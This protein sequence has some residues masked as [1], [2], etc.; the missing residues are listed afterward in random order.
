MAYQNM[1]RVA[2]SLFRKEPDVLI[3]LGLDKPVPRKVAAFSQVAFTL[4]NTT[5]Y[6]QPMRTK[7]AEHGY[8]DGKL[9]SERSKLSAFDFAKANQEACKGAAQRA[10]QVQHE[11]LRAM[12][13]WYSTYVN[14][15]RVALRP[16]P[17]LL[18]KL[19]IMYRSVKTPAQRQAPLK[20]A[21]TRRRKKEVTLAKA[22]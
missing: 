1:A 5:K 2:R 13:D 17:E 22:A 18:E 3:L 15:A 21:E 12:R 11:A 14:V 20:A 8:T 10:K 16:K 19:G 7:L 9:S 6:T 4:F